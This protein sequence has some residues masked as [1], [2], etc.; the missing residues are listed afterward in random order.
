M[1]T[2]QHRLI[3][4]TLASLVR[5]LRG[6]PVNINTLRRL[7][8]MGSMVFYLPRDV[9]TEPVQ[10]GHVPAEWIIPRKAD[11][12]KVLLYF[13]GGGYAVGGTQTHRALVAEIAKQTG[14]CALLPEYRLAPEDPFPAAVQDAVLC[15]KWLLETGHAAED[16]IIAGDSAGGG[17]SMA[18]MLDA[19]D[20]GLPMPGASVLISPWVDLTISQASVYENIDKSPILYLREMHAWAKNYA[21]DFPTDHPLVSP[22][23]A[24]LEG[25]PP[26]LIQVSDTEVLVDEDTLLAKRAEEAGVDVELRIWSGLIHVWHIYWRYLPHA[27]DAIKEIATFI[28][29]HSPAEQTPPLRKQA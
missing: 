10:V 20:K 25:L 22:L 23:Y 16:I 26:I 19:R 6:A 21:G 15:Y 11:H 9:E 5:P 4:S 2:L 24:D 17:L 3:R 18:C 28:G 14:Y 12:N 7:M 13:H 1:P 8:N 29:K 27:R